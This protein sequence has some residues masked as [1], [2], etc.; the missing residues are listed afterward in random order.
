M[1]LR[2]PL[3]LL[4]LLALVASLLALTPVGPAAAAVACTGTTLLQEDFEDASITYTASVP[5]F[6]DG[7]GDFFTRTDGSNVGSF[8]EIAGVQ[9]TSYFAAMDTDGDGRPA[10]LTL[11]WTG[12]DITGRVA[13]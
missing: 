9:G 6:T 13:F 12:L 2:R 10:V 11:N 1:S 4:A 8:Y 3:V 5:E 7:A